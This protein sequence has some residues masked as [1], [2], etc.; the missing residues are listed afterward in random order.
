MPIGPG[1]TAILYSDGVTEIMDNQHNLFR[2]D[3]LRRAIAQ[4]PVGAAPAGQSIL[5]AIRRFRQEQ[6][7]MD[8]MTL[9][10]LGRKLPEPNR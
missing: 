10:C 6:V 3:R 2:L 1:E 9:L 8:D 4:A 5:E 7:Q